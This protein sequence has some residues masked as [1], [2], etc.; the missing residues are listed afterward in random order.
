[1]V[2]PWRSATSGLRRRRIRWRLLVR[3]RSL[4]GRRSLIGRSLI[5]RTL[6]AA[7][8]LP[9]LLHLGAVSLALLTKLVLLVGGQDA[10]DLSAQVAAGVTIDRAP[11][12][13][14]LRI[15]VDHRPD[16]LLLV[17]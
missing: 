10:H 2:W 4:V 13:M 15:L 11:L 7:L 9:A 14:A 17:P 3:R 6:L 8:L 12:R 5:G 1:M 16:A